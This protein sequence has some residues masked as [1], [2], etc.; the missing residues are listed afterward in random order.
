MRSIFNY[1]LLLTGLTV[2]MASCNKVDDLPFYGQGSAVS[3][4]ASAAT[5]A[6]TPADSAKSVVDFTWSDPKYATDTSTYKFI[7]EIDSAGKNFSKPYTKELLGKRNFSLTGRE[8][9]AILLGYGFALDKS[10]ALDVRDTSSYANNNERYQ[11]NTVKLM[12]TPFA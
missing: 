4:T 5:V 6:P 7:V 10:H 11:S 3:L 9:N 12:V 8:L 1:I 2:F